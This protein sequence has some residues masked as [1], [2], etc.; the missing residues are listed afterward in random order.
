MVNIEAMFVSEGWNAPYFLVTVANECHE[1]PPPR[2]SMSNR[3]IYT[4]NSQLNRAFKE[5]FLHPFIT[6]IFIITLWFTS[7]FQ[8]HTF[9]THQFGLHF[10]PRG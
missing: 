2:H 7:R 3:S 10:L 9:F 4:Q 1:A 6:F 5:G 8:C